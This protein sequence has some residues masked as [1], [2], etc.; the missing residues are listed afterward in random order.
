MP[1]EQLRLDGRRLE[2]Y[3]LGYQHQTRLICNGFV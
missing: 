3:L 1:I 2:F